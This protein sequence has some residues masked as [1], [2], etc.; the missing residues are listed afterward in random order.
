MAASGGYYL[1]SSGNVI[2]ADPTAIVGSIGV[3]GGKFVLTDLFNKVGL[4][5]ETFVRGKNADLFSSTIEWDDQQREQLTHWM[6]ATYDQFTR[7]VMT[8]R[9]GKIKD[10]DA[11][12]RGR[13]FAA[14]QAKD[15][16][17][18]DQIGGIQDAVGYA[19]KKVDLKP[20]EFDVRVLPAPKTLAEL[21]NGST[22]GSDEDSVMRFSPRMSMEAQGLFAALGPS[23]QRTLG[24]ELDE[25]MLLQQRPVM[26]TS[27]VMFLVR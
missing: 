17:M 23:M 21:L 19:A 22:S 18:V 4:N 10:I 5:T 12:A 7:R 13:I 9:Q 1:A 15:L 26:L 14:Q 25:L 6:R 8:T 27:P 20:G 16:G 2:F 3:V 24:M 11:V